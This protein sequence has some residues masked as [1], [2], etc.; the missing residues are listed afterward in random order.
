MI[1]FE[2]DSSTVSLVIMF[3]AYT[4]QQHPIWKNEAY[5]EVLKVAVH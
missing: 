3:F 4:K 2:A 1:I 5:S